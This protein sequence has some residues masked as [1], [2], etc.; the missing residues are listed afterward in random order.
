[1]NYFPLLENEF[2]L[3]G[4]FFP[5]LITDIGFLRRPNDKDCIRSEVKRIPDTI[6]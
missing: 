2:P 1:M 5:R 3:K 6:G 4:N